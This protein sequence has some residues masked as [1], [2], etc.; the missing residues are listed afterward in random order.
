[1]STSA[2]PAPGLLFGIPIDDLTMAD[3]LAEIGRLVEIGRATGRT[4]QVVTVN[5]DFVVNALA[6]PEVHG[7]LQAADLAMADG[8]PV[9]VAVRRSGTPIRERVA[10]ADLVPELAAWSAATGRSVHLF[11]SRDGVAERAAELLREQ[12]PGTRLTAES[13][14]M[15]RDVANAPNEVIESIRS[16]DAD[17]VC[18]AFGNP[19]Q[20]RFIRYHGGAI[21]AP[22]MI[23]IGGSLDMLVGGKRRAPEWV[24]RS[25]LEFVWRA[26]Q[27]PGR[28]GRRYAHDARVFGP[29]A[30]EHERLVR[31]VRSAS[32]IHLAAVANERPKSPSLATNS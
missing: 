2:T 18:I 11:G 15:L 20:E 3:T 9:V 8:M 6:D 26:A 30:V 28:L 7:I 27:E 16:V 13:G 29:R 12:H 21:G 17:V 19:K 4:H 32:S 31:G 23:G 24:Q 10:G 14:P 22:V 25:G 5:V 1:M